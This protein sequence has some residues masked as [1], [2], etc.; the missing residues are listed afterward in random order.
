MDT[1][2][3]HPIFT[4]IAGFAKNQKHGSSQITLSRSQTDQA[5]CESSP[6]ELIDFATR[7]RIV[8]ENHGAAAYFITIQGIHYAVAAHS[9]VDAMA[10]VMADILQSGVKSSAKTPCEVSW[11]YACTQSATLTPDMI[12]EGKFTFSAQEFCSLAE[13]TEGVLERVCPGNPKMN[14]KIST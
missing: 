10:Y 4:W 13:I 2:I 11:S 8:I 7:S 5:A 1:K 12:D 14:R 9:L 6:C 3:H